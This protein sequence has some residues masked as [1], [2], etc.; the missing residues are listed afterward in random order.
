MERTEEEVG[1]LTRN[2]RLQGVLGWDPGK[3]SVEE[4]Y[5]RVDENVVDV[6]LLRI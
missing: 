6:R 2:V 1:R 5:T 4:E 3:T